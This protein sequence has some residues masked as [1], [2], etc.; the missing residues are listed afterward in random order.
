[1]DDPLLSFFNEIDQVTSTIDTIDTN[2]VTTDSIT[3]TTATATATTTTAAAVIDSST[4]RDRD[5]DDNNTVIV[6]RAKIVAASAPASVTI[7]SI[8][9]INLPTVDPYQYNGTI[10]TATS[11]SSSSS[12][13]YQDPKNFIKQNKK[14]VRAGGGDI[15]TDDTLND[16]PDNDYRLFIGDI[17]KDVSADML[18]KHFNHYKSFVKTRLVKPK[19]ETKG[20]GYGFVSF[21]DPLECAKALR[22]QQGKYLGSRPMTIEISKREKRDIKEVRKKEK[23]EHQ[24]KKSL[25]L[26]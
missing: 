10:A 16:W 7:S 22:E 26:D 25:G 13:Q 1:M 6:K 19:Y 15:W 8:P 9:S 24:V 18:E 3:T 12:I 11:S 20:R 4:K 14:Q 5:D 23:K 17:G 21:L 2:T